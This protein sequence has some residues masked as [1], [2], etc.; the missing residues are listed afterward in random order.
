MST[1][2]ATINVTRWSN[3]GM[4]VTQSG[5]GT[6]TTSPYGSSTFFASSIGMPSTDCSRAAASSGRSCFAVAVTG[7]SMTPLFAVPS[8]TWMDVESGTSS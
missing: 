4:L 6:M 8:P 1:G 7:N 3:V 5:H 2:S